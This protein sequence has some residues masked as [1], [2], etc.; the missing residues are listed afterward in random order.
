MALG[1]KTG[2]RIKGTPNKSTGLIA[3]KCRALLEDP[4]YQDY[5]THR[6]K[7]GALPPVLEALMWHYAYG[8]PKELHEHSGPDGGP[9][10]YTWLQPQL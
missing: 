10:P 8:K 2:G 7:Q 5:F 9:I 3:E 6:L 1:R 4:G